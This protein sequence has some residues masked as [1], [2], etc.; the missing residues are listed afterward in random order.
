[1]RAHEG[2]GGEERA[3]KAWTRPDG[4]CFVFG[5]ADSDLPLGRVYAS[6]E[7]TNEAWCRPRSPL[8][9]GATAE[10]AKDG[11]PTPAVPGVVRGFK[12]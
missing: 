3:L 1:M 5:E 6:A 11:C 8:A 10:P 2:A 4:R 7:E 9:T 12:T